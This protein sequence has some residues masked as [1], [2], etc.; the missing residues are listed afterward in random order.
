MTCTRLSGSFHVVLSSIP[1]IH[2]IRVE[3][4][5]RL[6]CWWKNP[7]VKVRMNFA[8][9]FKALK[10]QTWAPRSKWVRQRSSFDG[11]GAYEWVEEGFTDSATL[12]N[13]ASVPGWYN[14]SHLRI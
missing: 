3:T 14:T 5:V 6:E 11:A 7:K 4:D 1:K 12:S 13:W 2:Q 10:L 9:S 8:R